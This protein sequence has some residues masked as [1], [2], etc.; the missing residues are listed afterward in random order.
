[1]YEVYKIKSLTKLFFFLIPKICLNYLERY[2]FEVPKRYVT[3]SLQ[4]LK[5]KKKLLSNLF[6]KNICQVFETT[7]IFFLLI[8]TKTKDETILVPKNEPYGI[9]KIN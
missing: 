2:Y 8:S 7:Y 9:D 4:K 5:K 3:W 6:S 1:M